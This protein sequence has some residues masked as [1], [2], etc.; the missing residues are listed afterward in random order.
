LATQK[1]LT[2]KTSV[3]VYQSIRRPF[4]DWLEF[5]ATMLSETHFTNV[6]VTSAS[7]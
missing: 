6:I 7:D 5:S 1:H 2:F 3:I 4:P